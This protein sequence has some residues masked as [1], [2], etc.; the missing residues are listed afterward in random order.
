MSSIAGKRGSK[1]N[2]VYSA[3]K[4]A[5]NGL[6][7]SLK[8]LGE[9]SIRVNAICPVLIKTKGL[10]KALKSKH[11]PANGKVNSFL[12]NFKNEQSALRRLPDADDVADLCFSWVL[13][14]P[15]Q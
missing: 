10:E 11:S 13:P 4:F 1:N 6:T 7:Q 3:S 5:I 8:E 15:N 9:F 14:V 12:K 2:S